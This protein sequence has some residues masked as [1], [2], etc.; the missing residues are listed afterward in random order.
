MNQVL[1]RLKRLLVLLFENKG[2]KKFTQD[3]IFQE[4]KWKITTLWFMKKK[5]FDQPVKNDFRTFEKFQ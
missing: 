1:N 3:I 2:D 5:M 4:E